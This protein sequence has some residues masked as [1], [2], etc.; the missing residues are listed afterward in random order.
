MLG[1]EVALPY[2]TVWLLD[3]APLG[4]ATFHPCRQRGTATDLLE[5]VVYSCVAW[6]FGVA[7]TGPALE[8]PGQQLCSTI[9]IKKEEKIF[10]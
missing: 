6:Q 9:G 4:L 7:P 5:F 1:T 8:L 3:V 10:S 2:C